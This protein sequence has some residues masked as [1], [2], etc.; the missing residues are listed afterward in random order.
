[1]VLLNT[2]N[3]FLHI[4]FCEMRLRVGGETSCGEIVLTKKLRQR[5][6]TKPVEFFEHA[7]F[8]LLKHA[9]G[10]PRCWQGFS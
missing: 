2:D 10:L 1:M 3:Y 7:H 9:G 6:I 8:V 4:W 5:N